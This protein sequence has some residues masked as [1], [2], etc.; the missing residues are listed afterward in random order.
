M[1]AP[2]TV[3]CDKASSPTAVLVKIEENT[4]A[5]PGLC[6][7]TIKLPLIAF[8]AGVNAEGVMVFVNARSARQRRAT[9]RQVIEVHPPAAVPRV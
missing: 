4:L 2:K 6:G 5:M 8:P 1:L 3:C 7:L 9:E